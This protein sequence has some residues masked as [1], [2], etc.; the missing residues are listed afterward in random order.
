MKNENERLNKENLLLEALRKYPKGTK[1]KSAMSGDIFIATGEYYV[2]NEDR[3]RENNMKGKEA[4]SPWLLY[5]SKWAEIL[6]LP[7]GYIEPIKEEII[8]NYPLF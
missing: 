6:E 2:N 5:N 4:T 3:V 1:Y 7:E 8:N